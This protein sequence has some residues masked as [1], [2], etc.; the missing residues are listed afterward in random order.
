M[1][2]GNDEDEGLTLKID[3]WICN[4]PTWCKQNVTIQLCIKQCQQL[5]TANVKNDFYLLAVTLELE[6]IIK[7]LRQ[8]I[9]SAEELNT[10][11]TL[12]TV[13]CE[14]CGTMQLN[15]PTH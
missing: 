11:C 3:A 13:Y 14:L 8:C 10:N 15:A 12:H 7:F 4:K 1:A 9:Q 2:Q 6:S 5:F